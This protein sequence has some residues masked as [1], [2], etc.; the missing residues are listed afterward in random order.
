MKSE[1]MEKKDPND[2]SG[3][4]LPQKKS[5]TG[6]W[7]DLPIGGKWDSNIH[8]YKMIFIVNMATF[9]Q[10]ASVVTSSISLPRMPSNFSEDSNDTTWPRDFVVSESDAF[11]ISKWIGRL[12]VPM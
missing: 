10:G 7:D 12:F 9:L 8:Q 1:I 11:W 2:D 6:F 4:E 5:P 3:S